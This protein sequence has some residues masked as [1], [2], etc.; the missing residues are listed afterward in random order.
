STM[1]GVA[2]FDDVLGIINYSVA[3]VIAGALIAHERFSIPT[4]LL[5]PLFIIT[6]SLVLGAALGSVF[7]AIT[8]FIKKETEGV[9]IMVIFG[10]LAGCFGLATVIGVNELLA[11]MT[12]G[13]VVVNFNEKR[14]KIFKVMERY[15]DELIFV[16]FFTLSGMHLDFSVLAATGPLLLCFILFRTVGKV[17][18][19]MLGAAIAGSSPSVR[20]YT[21]GGLIPQGGIVIGLALMMKQDPAFEAISDIMI[22]LIIGSAV[23]H[24]LVGPV[25]AK[26]MLKKAGEIETSGGS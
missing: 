1:L 24:E 6:G 13:V 22:S 11:I 21:A 15:V 3:V 23:I 14:E 17:S 5:R 16:L 25:L 9:F 20:K 26:I 7:N 19:T 10:L 18:G 2:A 12:M 4:T 8:A